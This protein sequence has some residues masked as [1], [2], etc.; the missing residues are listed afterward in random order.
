[1]SILNDLYNGI[2]PFRHRYGKVFGETYDFLMKSQQWSIGQ[3]KDYQFEELKKTLI[4][5]R[6]NTEYYKEIFSDCE[7]IPEKM[8]SPKDIEVLPFLTKDIINERFSDLCY[9][10]YSGKVYEMKTSGSTGTKLTFFGTDDTYKKEAAFV[11]R[12]YKNHGGTLYDQPS[13]W[14]RR[15][16]PE[17]PSDPL[18]YYNTELRRL[19]MSAYHL[20]GERLLSYIK[21]MNARKYHTLVGY[22]S[23]I[24]SLACLLEEEGVEPPRY[25]KAIHVASE[26]LLP[27]WQHKIKEVFGI[28]PKAHYGQIEKV[29]LFHQQTATDEYHEDLEYGYTEFINEDNSKVV[30]GT[31][32][33]NEAM[34][35]IRY[36]TNDTV[37][38]YAHSNETGI[39]RDFDGR[40]DDI[41]L[42]LDGSRIPGVNF[43]T[44]MYKIGGVKMFEIRQ[45]ARHIVDVS[46]VLNSNDDAYIT[47]MKVEDGLRQ[48]L[49]EDMKVNVTLHPAIMRSTTTGKIRCIHNDL[50]K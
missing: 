45:S 16:V 4:H 17:S 36:K 24:Y 1:M 28:T 23:S 44:M 5:A 37:S 18:W 30:V 50:P 9:K 33:I 43:Y 40:C 22:P 25:I 31:G 35:F 8:Q 41:L 15:Y 2:V 3:R 48:R 13:V 34:P 49:G 39:V 47:I 46:I 27:Q 6:D 21:E 26:K 11:L 32:F 19:Y 7:F 14:L 12:A 42:A 29:S 10:E 20:N 38:L